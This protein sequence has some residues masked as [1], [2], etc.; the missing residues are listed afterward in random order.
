MLQSLAGSGF[1]A[2]D[3]L[4]DLKASVLSI[5][6][7]TSF[8]ASVVPIMEKPETGSN[9]YQALTNVYDGLGAL[10]DP[11]FAEVYVK[12]QNPSGTSLNANLFEAAGQATAVKKVAMFTITEPTLAPTAGAIYEDS[13]LT[14]LT[15]VGMAD[16]TLVVEWSGATVPVS[17]TL[18]KVS[19]TGD[20]TISSS[21]VD[22]SWAK[23]KK[24]ALGQYSVFYNVDTLATKQ[25]ITFRFGYYLSG[26]WRGY[27]RASSV[28]DYEATATISGDVWEQAT[29]AHTTAGTF[30]LLV[31]DIAGSGFAT[32]TDSLVALKGRLNTVDS[33]LST[34]DT[35]VGL[36]QIDV[37]AIKTKTD[38][39]PADTATVLSTISGNVDDIEAAIG[40]PEAI[41]GGNATVAGMLRKIFDDGSGY[42]SATDSLNALR[43]AIDSKPTYATS[44]AGSKATASLAQSANE[45]LEFSTAEG[46][47]TNNC[48]LLQLKATVSG[49]TTD[50]TI[51]VYEK[52]GSQNLI[53]EIQNI[54]A[55]GLNLALPSVIFRNADNTPVNKVYVKVTNVADAGNSTV[56]VELRGLLNAN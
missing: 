19:G 45:M 21:A 24:D 46:L 42:D 12:T 35:E 15:V 56:T 25:N 47:T 5:Q 48:T 31:S 52:S 44:F 13:N 40:A 4:K 7:N 10:V 43:S 54:D 6:N 11:D 18:T 9:D 2:T 36:V 55:S 33:S 29:S 41:D 39:L 28:Q 49:A 14:S 34:I 53:Y 27:D 16:S 3:S 26:L 8:T 51:Q 22:A 37:T 30:G 32:A 50:F 20:A 1:S 23:L 17:G 38:N